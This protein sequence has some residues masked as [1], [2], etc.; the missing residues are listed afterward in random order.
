MSQKVEQLVLEYRWSWWLSKGFLMGCP[1]AVLSVILILCLSS[2]SLSLFALCP[3]RISLWLLTLSSKTWDI[4]ENIPQKST[5]NTFD[6]F[7]V[8][9]WCFMTLFVKKKY[10]R[11]ETLDETGPKLWPT[12]SN[13]A[14]QCWWSKKL[15]RKYLLN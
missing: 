9:V 3:K 13:C 5:T 8:S 10:R 4:P 2:H 1:D 12:K 15:K 6:I 11:Q 14:Y 7:V